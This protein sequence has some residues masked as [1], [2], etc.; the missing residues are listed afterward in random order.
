MFRSAVRRVLLYM[1]WIT[2]EPV[3]EE[4]TDDVTINIRMALQKVKEKKRLTLEV[5]KR[6]RARARN[7][8]EEMRIYAT[9]VIVKIIVD[10]RIGRYC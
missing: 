2:E 8:R 1:E 10:L 7:L 3:T 6:A 9:Y 5:F 4:I